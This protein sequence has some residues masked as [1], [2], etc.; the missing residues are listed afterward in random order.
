[1]LAFP[2]TISTFFGTGTAIFS[3][4]DLLSLISAALIFTLFFYYPLRM[5]V[6][7][8]YI[9]IFWRRDVAPY[10]AK[11]KRLFTLLWFAT[12]ATLLAV[13]C[14]PFE[15]KYIAGYLVPVLFIGF[16]IG[17][18]KISY[19]LLNFSWAL[20]ALFLLSYNRNFLQGVGS[21]YSLAFILSV[22]ISF[23]ICLLYMARIN[24]R[25]E[26]LNR[27]W[28]SQALTDPLTQLPNLRALE[29]FLLQD[30]G[31]S[32]C[33]LRMENLEFLSRHYGMQMRV[34]CEREVFRVLQPL[35][36]EKE[37]IFHLP[38]SE[39]LLVLTGP[40]TEARL[41]YM[42]NV[43]NNRKIYWNNTGLDMEYGA[44]W[45]TF[46]G[47][48]ETLQPLLGQLSWLA[49]QSCSHRRVLAL[50]QSIEAA[51]GQTTERVLRLQKIRQ[52][53][54]RGALV[55][56]AQP[57]R[58]AQ[59]KGYDE[60]LTRLRCD[61]GIMMPNQFIPLIAQFNLSVRFDMQ[62]MEAL[63]QWLSA[64]PSAEQ[65]A[66]FSV[67]LMPLTLLQK[68]TASR[69][70]QLFKRYGVPPAS[71]I[72]EITEEQAFSHSEI[73]MHNINQL[74]KFGLKIAID[75][76]GTGYANYERLKR[77]KAD[78]IKIDGCFVKDIL[79]DS[80]DAMIVKSITDLAKAKSLSV[81]AEFVE[82]PAQRD[83][84]LQLGVHSLQGYLIGRPR[85]LGK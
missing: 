37:K 50:T 9:R 23:S 43:L 57:I 62:V 70:M 14:T 2:V 32:V 58:D 72:I 33:Y 22:L 19:P 51:S 25:S 36:L 34:H 69:I 55:L 49:E 52:A 83:L 12:L 17:V 6:S 47:R 26:W 59:G 27:Q 76:F 71:V 28:H 81:V 16:T 82:T 54:E 78:I 63:L 64:H 21:E 44:S 1:L 41:Q 39:L 85:P 67:N 24:Q 7:P 8:H 42:L 45:G 60:I 79:T 65:G 46:D 75:D 48:Q 66:R 11:E 10:L 56:Y 77:L 13:L 84:L 18:G 40:E 15:T 29:Q 31:Q 35:L 53:L 5:I 73:S 30:A 74:R 20:T 3:I 61:D 68:E 38:G 4:V 80:L